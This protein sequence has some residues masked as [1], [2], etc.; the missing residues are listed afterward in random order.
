MKE[1]W[2]IQNGNNTDQIMPNFEYYT[3]ENWFLINFYYF[4]TTTCQGKYILPNTLL[5]AYD[6]NYF[7]FLTLI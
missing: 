4:L 3:F 6:V 5:I 7:L 2:I 1:E